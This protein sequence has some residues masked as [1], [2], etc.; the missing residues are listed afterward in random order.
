[1]KKINR[2]EALKMMGASSAM[3]PLG[4]SRSVLL[5]SDKK[6]KIVVAGA[7][8][9][10]PETGCGGTMALL[11]DQGHEVISL[12]LTRGEAGIPGKSHDE[13]ARIRTAEVKKACEILK[14]RPVFAGQIDGDTK[15]SNQ[16]YKEFA[17]ILDR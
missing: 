3:L 5:G 14:A 10:D 9:D 7:H 12:Y 16:H 8:P 1:M 17:Q 11:A 2:R 4:L 6:L 13:A 15:I